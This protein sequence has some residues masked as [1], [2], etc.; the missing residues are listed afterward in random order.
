MRG[1]RRLAGW[2]TGPPGRLTAASAALGAGSFPDSAEVGAER[3][4]RPLPSPQFS[5]GLLRGQETQHPFP[6]A[7]FIPSSAKNCP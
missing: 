6:F 5:Q 4:P 1:I 7:S 2:E 3:S